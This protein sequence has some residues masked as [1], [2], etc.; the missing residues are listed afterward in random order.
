MDCGT[1]PPSGISIPPGLERSE[2]GRRVGSRTGRVRRWLSAVRAAKVLAACQSL[3]SAVVCAACTRVSRGPP[4]RGFVRDSVVPKPGLEPGRGCPQRFGS[5]ARS[6]RERPPVAASEHDTQP[7]GGTRG[8]VCAPLLLP[9]LLPDRVGRLRTR[10]VAS[11]PSASLPSPPRRS[12][13]GPPPLLSQPAAMT[14]SAARSGRSWR[15]R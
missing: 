13:G 12:G 1:S 5:S 11:L 15:C 10:T 6:V 4:P 9:L 7:V 2:D 3:P 14:R 8:W